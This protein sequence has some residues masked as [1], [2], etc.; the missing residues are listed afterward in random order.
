MNIGASVLNGLVR[1]I[2]TFLDS[3]VYRWNCTP[4]SA[5][6][7]V[8]QHKKQT[9]RAERLLPPWRLGMYL[10]YHNTTANHLLRKPHSQNHHKSTLVRWLPYSYPQSLGNSATFW[11]HGPPTV[12]TS[13]T[14][15]ARN[16]GGTRVHAAATQQEEVCWTHRFYSIILGRR[17]TSTSCVHTTTRKIQSLVI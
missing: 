2:N 4:S 8:D 17:V 1:I 3:H 5:F 15:L 6:V 7:V 13:A 11:C 12:F 10:P 16:C 9:E 14:E